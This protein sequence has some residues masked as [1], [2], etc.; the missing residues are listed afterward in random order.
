IPDRGRHGCR[1]QR[2]C[3]RRVSG[4]PNRQTADPPHH[5]R[6]ASRAGPL[7]G[8]PGLLID[9]RAKRNGAST[10]SAGNW[11]TCTDKYAQHRI[12]AHAGEPWL[13]RNDAPYASHHGQDNLGRAI[14]GWYARTARRFAS[15]RLTRK[16]KKP[17]LPQ[18]I[19]ARWPHDEFGINLRFLGQDVDSS[20][21]DILSIVKLV[22]FAIRH[23]STARPSVKN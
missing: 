3:H 14:G 19:I 12:A 8:V 1:Y 17:S 23:P 16:P 7:R 15:M 10:P 9:R 11:Q 13:P 6:R 4:S 20:A 22:P 21:L 2:S 18:A 5:S